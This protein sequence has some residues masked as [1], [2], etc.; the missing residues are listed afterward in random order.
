MW[1][2]GIS[3]LRMT[4]TKHEDL[5]EHENRG[6]WK[7]ITATFGGVMM[8]CRR[9]NLPQL[10]T[11]ES[12]RHGPPSRFLDQRRERGRPSQMSQEI[13]QEGAFLTQVP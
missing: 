13:W 2:G 6:E 5:D 11:E 4:L 12:R 3:Q 1:R 9:P 8:S 7:L 10:G